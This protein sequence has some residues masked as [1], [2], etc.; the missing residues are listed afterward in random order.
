MDLLEEKIH[1]FAASGI[2]DKELGVPVTV[3]AE[4]FNDSENLHSL[5]LDHFMLSFVL[6]GVGL[7]LALHC[8]YLSMKL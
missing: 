7:C 4:Q 6:L 8:W 5:S 3:A 2:I 1:H